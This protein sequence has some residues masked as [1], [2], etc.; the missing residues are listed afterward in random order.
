MTATDLNLELKHHSCVLALA[1][2]YNQ[3]MQQ[4]MELEE[5]ML[6]KEEDVRNMGLIATKPDL[7]VSKKQDSNQFLSYRDKLKIEISPV[8]SLDMLNL[9]SE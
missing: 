3:E 9:K 5:A 4:L 7:R 2:L 8:A 1:A 6:H